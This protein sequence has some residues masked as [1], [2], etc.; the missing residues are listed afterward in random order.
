MLLY[1]QGCCRT[2]KSLT[3]HETETS[4]SSSRSA[5][6]RLSK[7]GRKELRRFFPLFLPLSVV[8]LCLNLINTHSCVLPSL[9][10]FFLF[11]NRMLKKL[12]KPYR[13]CPQLNTFQLEPP[14]VYKCQFNMIII[15]AHRMEIILRSIGM[16]FF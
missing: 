12:L 8:F 3:H 13:C 16:L 1:W 5:D 2:G 9:S 14:T 11:N 4:P 15:L 6:R 7:A 10:R